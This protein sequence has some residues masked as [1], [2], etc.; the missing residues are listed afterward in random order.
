VN[1]VLQIFDEMIDKI[2]TLLC[3]QAFMEDQKIMEK[4]FT[5]DEITCL[6]KYCSIRK[7]DELDL[8][9]SSERENIDRCIELILNSDL[10][11]MNTDAYKEN[12]S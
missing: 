2:E 4:Y 1:R 3:I 11:L 5:R 9:N 8:S 10:Y 6:Q 7:D 12:V